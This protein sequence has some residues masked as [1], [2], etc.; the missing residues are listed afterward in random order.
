MDTHA[1]L[2]PLIQFYRDHRRMP[3][4]QELTTL[5]GFRSKNATTRVLT[6]LLAAGL[7]AKDQTG[8]LLP[9]DHFAPL[10]V[11]GTVEAGF[12][13]PAEEE[14]GDTLDLEDFLIRNKEATYML[15]VT[16][17]SMIEAGLLPGD[18]VLVERRADAKD[19]DIVIA[20][21]DQGWTMKYLRRRGRKLW[22]E[23]ANKKYK[24]IY[25]AQELKIAAVVIAAIRKY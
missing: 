8:K 5:Y 20:Q 13:S 7:V 16:G 6:K 15:K 24:P 23:P 9:T 22:L 19:G 12:P 25:P 4:V 17:D 10:R 11:L 2:S 18:L 3:S 14:L 21:I 1:L